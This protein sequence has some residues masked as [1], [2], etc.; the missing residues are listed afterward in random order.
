MPLAIPFLVMRPAG[1]LVEAAFL[2]RQV[3]ELRR[4]ILRQQFLRDLRRV[5]ILSG[6][7]DRRAR[8]GPTIA[9]S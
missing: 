4:K 2:Q 3:E 5:S 7:A 9:T 1:V 8:A 6:G